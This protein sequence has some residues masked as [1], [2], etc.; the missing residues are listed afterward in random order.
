MNS[1]AKTAAIRPRPSAT[2]SNRSS[3]SVPK[4]TGTN[5]RMNS[6]NPA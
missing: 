1:A 5:R 3:R 6:F 2:G 4:I